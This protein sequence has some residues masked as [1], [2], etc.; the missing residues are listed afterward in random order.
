MRPR[1]PLAAIFLLILVASCGGRPDVRVRV[2]GDTIPT[3]L[4][5]TSD[6]TA[7]S[8]SIGDAFPQNVPLT[9]VRAPMPVKLEFEA[10][11][12]ATEIRGAIYDRDAP[13]GNPT[14]EFTLQGD[15]GSYELRT[16]VVARTYRVL[17]N[18]RWSIVVAHGEVTH[19][20]DL[21][22]QPG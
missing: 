8:T 14:E 3:V 10:G 19:L 12:G 5:S 6:G 7:C 17:V 16:P 9:I 22:V 15:S 4:A 20:F 18:V 2:A 1:V 21:R 11:Q 13:P